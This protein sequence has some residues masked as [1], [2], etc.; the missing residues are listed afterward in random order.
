MSP[1]LTAVGDERQLKSGKD[2]LFI[3]LEAGMSLAT[4]VLT[5]DGGLIDSRLYCPPTG[6]V[7]TSCHRI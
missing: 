4:L 6:L 3:T 7:T 1:L 2:P 5:P